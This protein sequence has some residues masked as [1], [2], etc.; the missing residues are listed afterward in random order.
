MKVL[1]IP[2]LMFGLVLSL[3]SF[4]FNMPFIGQP[5]PVHPVLT[6]E[7]KISKL[8][9][10]IEKTEAKF[11]RNGTEYNGVDAAKHLLMKRQRAGKRVKTA[12]EFIDFL[13]SKSSTTNEPYQMKFKNGSI[14][15]VRDILYNELRKMEAKQVG[16]FRGFI[17][18]K[19]PAC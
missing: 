16:H 7:Q 13:A 4:A 17:A 15:N 1:Q 3:A 9:S 8:I 2:F 18:I 5:T 10:F 14:L 11:I 12:K 19:V 6:E